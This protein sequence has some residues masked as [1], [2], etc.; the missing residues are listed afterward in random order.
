MIVISSRQRWLVSTL[1]TFSLLL[2]L[3]HGQQPARPTDGSASSEGD[4]SRRERRFNMT[5]DEMRQRMSAALKEQFKVENDEEW[6]LISERITKVQELRRSTMAG[7]GFMGRPMGGPPAGDTT[8]N[9]F[10]TSMMGGAASPEVQALSAAIRNNAT[11]ADLKARLERL[12][13][14]RKQNEAKLAAAQDELRAVLDLRQESIAV[15]M[16]L[17]P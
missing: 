8:G 15:L 13:E 6:A 16:G 4:S 12:R 9:R 3:G 5:P 10:R 1:G 11:S 14:S 17:L 7:G 2:S